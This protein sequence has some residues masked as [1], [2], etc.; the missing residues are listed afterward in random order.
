M[1]NQKLIN[2]ILGYKF[3]Q[4]RDEKDLTLEEVSEGIKE[5]IKLSP[6]MLSKIENGKTEIYNSYLYALSSFYEKPI[7]DYFTYLIQELK[8]HENKD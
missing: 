5:E 6:Q 8:K 4:D 3:K 7:D 2:K 1:K